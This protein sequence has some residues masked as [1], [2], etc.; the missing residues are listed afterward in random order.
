MLMFPQFLVYKDQRLRDHECL[1]M[2]V[3]KPVQQRFDGVE[4]ST[5]TFAN[6]QLTVN[7]KVGNKISKVIPYSPRQ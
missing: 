2:T 3:M 5:R 7:L 1:L 4:M 6:R